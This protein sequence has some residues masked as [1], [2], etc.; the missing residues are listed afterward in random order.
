MMNRNTNLLIRSK[1]L[2]K[3]TIKIYL[4]SFDSNK[5]RLIY[6]FLN[7]FHVHLKCLKNYD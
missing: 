1:T 2:K 5:L 7:I 4:F 6:D 3:K